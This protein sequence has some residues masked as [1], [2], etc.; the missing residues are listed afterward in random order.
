LQERR[1]YW[2][3]LLY[4]L[5][6]GRPEAEKPLKEMDIFDFYTRL[7]IWET[8]TKAKIERLNSKK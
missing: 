3:S 1:Q 8:E 7:D 2:R 6:E 4:T 5:S